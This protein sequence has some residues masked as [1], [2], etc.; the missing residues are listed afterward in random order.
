MNFNK[1]LLKRVLTTIFLFIILN[2]GLTQELILTDTIR[3]CQVD[4]LELT[5]DTD[6]IFDSYLW[7]N[8]DTNQTT[9]VFYSGDYWVNVTQ[10]DTVDITDSVFAIIV[11]A[12]IVE[13]DTS[14]LCRDTITLH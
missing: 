4:S 14:I 11:D 5:L 3:S 9:W 2:T 8:G 12:K 1:I 13:N 6:I 7:N 10:G